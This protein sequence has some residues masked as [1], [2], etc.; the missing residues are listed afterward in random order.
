M[1]K[2]VVLF[3]REN[4][5]ES[6]VDCLGKGMFCLILM[7]LIP[8]S[9][10]LGIIDWQVDSISGSCSKYTKFLP[11]LVHASSLCFT[12]RFGEGG[13]RAGCIRYKAS[14]HICSS[15]PR[16][17]KLKGSFSKICLKKYTFQYEEL[18]FSLLLW[19]FPAS[20]VLFKKCFICN[21]LILVQESSLPDWKLNNYF[22]LI[23][24]SLNWKFPNW[25][26][27]PGRVLTHKS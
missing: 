15:C 13:W 14:Q 4:F 12:T 10:F 26:N 27:V 21:S 9:H 1:S 25:M 20:I 6:N 5:G 3:H 11:H 18:L 16:G 22:L 8:D 7:R 2:P 23:T 19:Q 17:R 24:F